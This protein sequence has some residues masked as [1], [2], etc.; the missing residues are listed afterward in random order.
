MNNYSKIKSLHIGQKKSFRVLIVIELLMLLLGIV[1]LFGEK[2]IYEYSI[3]DAV[4]LFGTYSEKVSIVTDGQNAQEGNMVSFEGIALSPGTYRVQLRY[5]TD[6]DAKNVYEVSDDSLTQRA[7]R[8]NPE[9]LPK[10]LFQTDSEMWLLR[11]TSDLTVRIYYGGTGTLGVQGLMIQETGAWDRILLFYMICLFTLL[12][13]VYCY[14]CYDRKYRIPIKN[15]TITFGLGVILLF[16]GMPLTRDYLVESGDLV[17]HLMRVEGIRDSITAGRFPVRISPEWQQ[18]YGYASPIFYGETLLYPAALFRIIGF[19]VTG[20]ARLYLLCILVATVLVAYYCFKAIFQE[21]Y[22]GLF[23][24]AL[25]SMSVYRIYKTYCCGSWGEM[26]GVMLLPLFVYGFWRVFGQ[27]VYEEGYRRNWIPLTAGFTLLVQSHLLTG[28]MVGV[29]TILL[30]FV[31]CRKV[32]RPRTFTVLAKTVIYSMLLS[33]WFLIP[34]VDYMLTGDFVIQ[35]VSARTIQYR[36]L[37]PAHLLFTFFRDGDT[38]MFDQDGMYDS[39]ATGV[40]VVLLMVLLCYACLC[41]AGKQK[42]LTKEERCL[43][44]VC[45]AFSVLALLMSLNIFPWDRIQALGDFAATLVSSIQFP[46][47]FLTI[48]NVGLTAVAGVVAKYVL[49]YKEKQIQIFWF[50][51]MLLLLVVG[52]VYLMEDMADRSQPVRIYNAKGMG[53][54]YISGAEYLPYGADPQL[55][56]HHDPVCSGELQA[57]GYEKE[58]LGATVR[59]TN[60]GTAPEQVAFALLYYK[61][62]HAYDMVTGQE[63]QCYA[64]ENSEVTVDI[65]AEFDGM[66]RVSFVSPWYWRVGEAVSVAVA[67]GMLMASW[68]QKKKRMKKDGKTA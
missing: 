66:V 26:L 31:F 9:V 67:A 8:I 10:G 61:G 63:L 65:P 64:G 29:F 25:Y 33:A 17:Y 62:Y 22:V 6:T 55:F 47:R 34:F 40:G 27:D 45:S 53:T 43:G 36:G 16:A 54:G 48:A 39:A 11:N 37:Y 18:G 52:S 38:V 5:F 59:L 41:F 14:V 19:S 42:E 35:H 12:N 51:G 30:C 2:K 7:L 49:T 57:D 24:S 44:S 20:A 58:S 21:A 56:L 32:I 50:G 46:N 68:H 1:G 60:P 13:V 28:E 4:C 23:C 3:E 15:K